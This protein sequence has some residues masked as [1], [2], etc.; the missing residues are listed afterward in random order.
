MTDGLGNAGDLLA[1]LAA[2]LASGGVDAA[3][4]PAPALVSS[5]EGD[6]HHRTTHNSLN[7]EAGLRR[8]AAAVVSHH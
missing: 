1:R 7:L 5:S 2:N 4:R 3:E 8:G 6:V